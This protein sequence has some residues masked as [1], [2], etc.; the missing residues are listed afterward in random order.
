MKHMEHLLVPSSQKEYDVINSFTYPFFVPKMGYKTALSHS[1]F[2]LHA[3]YPFRDDDESLDT[4]IASKV[5]LS[6]S[7]HMSPDVFIRTY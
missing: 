5:P 6:S 2:T 1:Y 4:A 7:S 3:D